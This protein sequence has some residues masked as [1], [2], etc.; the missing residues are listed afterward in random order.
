MTKLILIRHG[1]SEANALD[2]FAGHSDFD[3]TRL[4]REQAARAAEWIAAHEAVDVIYASDLLRAYHTA[5]PLC[6]RLG[7]S[8]IPDKDLREIF[9]GEWEGVSFS[10]IAHRYPDAF[11]IWREDY[12]NARPVG[13]EATA[14]VYARV[15]P[16]IL[17]I[18]AR[19]EG[20]TVV[21]ATHATVVRAFHAYA[22]G[23]GARD[24]DKV[25]FCYNASINIYAYESGTVSPIR[26]NVVEHLDGMV[27]ALPP[28][29]N[30]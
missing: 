7:L 2:L 22:N 6:E 11:G 19:H 14:E 8:V 9:A 4:G 12:A 28:I 25:S 23:Y 5:T 30:A 17:E 21:V 24:T 15:V 13:G 16:H 10:E 27:S 18:A 1:Q 29:I 20:Q 26:T 3:L